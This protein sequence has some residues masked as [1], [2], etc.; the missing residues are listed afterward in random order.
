VKKKELNTK[1]NLN[2]TCNNGNLC[3][4]CHHPNARRVSPVD[5]WR[6]VYVKDVIE[7]NGRTW[8]WCHKHKMPDYNGLYVTHHPNDHDKWVE[9]NAEIKK[10][11]ILKKTKNAASPSSITSNNSSA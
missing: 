1:K 9:K 4:P 3:Q 2:N 8:Y 11:K 5:P 10:Q 7:Y 6:K